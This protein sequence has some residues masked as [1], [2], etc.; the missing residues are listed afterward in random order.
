[1]RSRAPDLIEPV[2]GF[3]KWR[4]VGER[5]K[6]PFI[7]LRWDEPVAH[8]R[9]YPANRSLLFGEGWLEAPHEAPHPD[10]RCG[11]YAWHDLPSPGPVPD[12]D[13]V[14]GAV[15][16]WGRI[17]AHA[18]GMRAQHARIAA[19]GRPGSMGPAQTARL[20][21]IAGRLG[22]A[23]VDEAELRSVALQHGSPLPAAMLPR[24]A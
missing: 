12:P 4:L 8:A 21:A 7:P 16:L 18:D 5:L 10:C 11:I 20:Q 9:C 22:V 24:A 3:R 19:L 14:F 17:E 13:R 1:M 15:A 6:S 2:V 23:L